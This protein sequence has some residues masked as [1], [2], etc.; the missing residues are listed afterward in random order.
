M[1]REHPDLFRVQ[2][3]LMAGGTAFSAIGNRFLPDYPDLLQVKCSR[4][5]TD[6]EIE[7]KKAYYLS[8]ARRGTPDLHQIAVMLSGCIFKK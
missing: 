7:E 8:A 6:D 5:L 4:S 1:K 3:G 2:H